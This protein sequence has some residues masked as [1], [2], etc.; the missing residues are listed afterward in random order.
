[1]SSIRAQVE[2]LGPWITG[3]DWEGVRYGG[4]YFPENDSRVVGFIDALRERR[5]YSP[6]GS[7]PLRILECGC[8]EGAH[9]IMLAKAFPQ[10]EIVAVDL[11]ETNLRKARFLA[12]LYGVT[13]I[14]WVQE[15]LSS[16]RSSFAESYDAIFCVGLLYHLRDPAMFLARAARAT[17]FLWLWTVICAETETTVTEGAFRGRML[18]EAPGH[19]LTGAAPQSFL[20]TLGSLVDMLWGAGFRSAGLLARGI[21]TNNNG[22]CVLLQ[23]GH[24]SAE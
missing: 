1:M 8:L 23:A 9:T 7:P 16:P 17:T 2:E 11:R 4:D 10:A 21:T 12:S 24:G 6:A 5:T 15:D 13:N 22:P 18:D 3:F 20:P 14:R 19:P